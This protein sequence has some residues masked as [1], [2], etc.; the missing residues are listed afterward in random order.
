MKGI[1]TIYDMMDLRIDRI[2]R[3]GMKLLESLQCSSG[4]NDMGKQLEDFIP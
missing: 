3:E 4:S 2:W 1:K